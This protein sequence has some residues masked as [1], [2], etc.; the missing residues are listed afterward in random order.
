[1]GRGARVPR[2]RRGPG[3][4]PLPA[5]AGRPLPAAGSR[6]P[7]RPGEARPRPRPRRRGARRRDP[8]AHAGHAASSGGPAASGVR[9][10]DRARPSA[11]TTS[12]SPR[13]PTRA[14][15]RRLSSQFVP[16]YDYVLVSEPLTPDQRAS[17]GWRRRQGMSDANNQF[18]YFRLTADDRILW[19]GYDAI[20]H[21]GNGVG[22]RVR[23]AAGD[24]RQ[25]RGAVPAGVPAARRPRV[26]V[27][28]G[29]R[30]RHD[31]AV[32]GHVRPGARRAADVRPRLHR[33]GRRGEPLGGRASS[34]TSSSDRTRTC[35]G[36]GSSRAGRSR[37]R[38]SRSGRSPST[39][40]ATSST[41]PTGTRAAAG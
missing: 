36:C 11:P 32:H 21:F 17:I 37:S 41:G 23:P 27:P 12:S 7:A 1:M 38:P 13:R 31:V 24:V 30:D 14:G 40:S 15:S 16:V 28:L 26:P 5:L 4:G 6:R 10:R 33:A 34:A 35:S 39:R 19:G 22:P 20:Y 25:A 2:P 9:D 8:R 29:R 18:H 3:R